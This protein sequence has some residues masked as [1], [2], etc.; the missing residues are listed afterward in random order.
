VSRWTRRRGQTEAGPRLAGLRSASPI[1]LALVALAL[2]AFPAFMPDYS[3]AL[4]Q[5]ILIFAILAIS[6]DLIYGYAGLPS[7]GQAAFLGVGGYAVGILMVKAGLTTVWLVVPGGILAGALAAAI[8]G[9]IVLRTSGLNFLLVTFAVGQL[10]ATVAL[11]VSFLHSFGVEGLVGISFPSLGFGFEWDPHSMYY[12]VVVSFAVAFFIGLWVTRSPLGF[13]AIGVRE[14]EQRM[15]VL[16]Y[17]TFW[18]KY[19]LFIISG[20][21]AALAGQLLAYTSGSVLPTNFDITY[22]G[23]VFLMVVLAGA[24]TIYGPAIGAAVIILLEYY[25][26]NEISDRWP[27][28]L[29]AV[30]LATAIFSRDGLVGMVSRGLTAIRDRLA[31]GRPATAAP[32]G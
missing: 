15:R 10:L 5:K 31:R 12:A 24:G 8:F 28:V 14:N 13:A 1:A 6:L 21:M 29:G 18:V 25:V 11:K 20:A 23:L 30:F 27:L 4:V 17:N 9:P 3:L 19:K 22:S 7:L 16:G 2:F 32:R 26:S